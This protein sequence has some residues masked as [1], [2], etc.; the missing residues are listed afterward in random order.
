MCGSIAM[1]RYV[2]DTSTKCVCE[3]YA[4]TM[5]IGQQKAAMFSNKQI[6]WHGGCVGEGIQ[7]YC[8]CVYCRCVSDCV[9]KCEKGKTMGLSTIRHAKREKIPSSREEE[10]MCLCAC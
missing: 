3:Y 6:S 4:V 10:C 5:Q 1:Y 7:Y 2:V 8:K 9:N